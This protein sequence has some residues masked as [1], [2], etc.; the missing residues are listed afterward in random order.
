MAKTQ[1]PP[2]TTATSDSGAWTGWIIFASL[3]LGVVG[4]INI[5]QGLVA[6]SRD[7]YF[8]VQ[9]GNDL[10]LFDFVAWGWVLIVW[11]CLQ[12]AAAVGLNMGMGWSRWLA[13]GIASIGIVIQMLFLSAY[14]IWSAM[15]I[16]LDVIVVYALTA[17]WAEARAGL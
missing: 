1:M 2:R 6:L 12:V 14:P 16:A 5:I 3:M 17:R 13:I 8:L 10:L 9:S 4:S 7:D 11:G 15:I